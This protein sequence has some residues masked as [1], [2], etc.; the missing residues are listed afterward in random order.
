MAGELNGSLVLL[1]L[2]VLGQW[3]LIGGQVSMTDTIA[4][5]PIDITNKSSQ[6]YRELLEGEGLLTRD[7]TLE[8]FYNSD[9]SFQLLRELANSGQMAEFRVLRSGTGINDDVTAM[10]SSFSE[11]APMS[12][13]VSNTI[14]L[15][16]G[17]FSDAGPMPPIITLQP[18]DQNA[19]LGDNITI[20]SR[21]VNW[22]SV[23]WYRIGPPDQN[24]GLRPSRVAISGQTSP[25]L[26]ITLN[27][28]D[29]RSLFQVVYS[30]A[31]GSAESRRA[32]II[33]DLPYAAVSNIFPV[34]LSDRLTSTTS[35]SSNIRELSVFY[36]SPDSA[37]ASLGISATIEQKVVNYGFGDD[38]QTSLSVAADLKD[39]VL[40]YENYNEDNINGS[41]SVSANI[42]T[43]GVIITSDTDSLNG[44]LSLS[45]TLEII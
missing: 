42:D 36:V 21:A 6:D 9:T 43:V 45:A 38:L 16:G 14:T 5:A 7:I 32:V 25:D 19:G 11:V 34:Q 20:I 39:V 3:R 15:A 41:V 17:Q 18:E 1:L 24:T 40:S 8:L 35:A 31:N 23:Q 30:N 37:I 22:S 2:K 12:D 26:N 29:V 33:G 28:N 10:V 13:K 4:A 44:S 27:E